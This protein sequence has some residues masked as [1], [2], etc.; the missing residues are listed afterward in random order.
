MATLKVARGKVK[1]LVRENTGKILQEPDDLDD[2]IERALE[3]HSKDDP[4]SVV[5]D[6]T[7][8]G[9]GAFDTADLEDESGE[10][11]FDADF[12]GDIEIEYPISTTGDPNTL[13]RRAWRFYQTPE[14]VQVRLDEAIPGGDSFRVTFKA[15]RVLKQN[16]HDNPDED[17]T[18]R[19]SS[20]NLKAFYKL[21]AAEACQVVSVHYSQTADKGTGNDFV[22]FTSKAK[23][24]ENRGKTYRTQYAEHMGKKEDDG[25]PAANV[26]V[27]LDLPSSQG[28]DRFHHRRRNR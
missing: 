8:D 2:A 7:S 6:L 24:Y 14:T 20:K 13:D 4:I 15:P 3:T 5:V 12:S 16:A 22:Q 23:V 17:A 9:S 10:L 19:V 11:V 21:A 28:L 18:L 25:A 27:N 26:I 1:G